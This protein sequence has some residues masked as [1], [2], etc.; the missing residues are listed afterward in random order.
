MGTIQNNL[1]KAGSLLLEPLDSQIKKAGGRG[2]NCEVV[3][4]PISGTFSTLYS[5]K[6]DS[7]VKTI[8][9]PNDFQVGI[10]DDA[11]LTYF[12]MFDADKGEY[13]L[14]TKHNIAKPP[15]E[16]LVVRT[17]GYSFDAM[18]VELERR[19]PHR[20]VWNLTHPAQALS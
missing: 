3:V 6:T 14:V 2:Y 12:V 9:T 1:I 15:H 4:K 13:S 19:W 16:I 10:V 5:F 11:E 8:Q 20:T 17:L 18:K 7:G